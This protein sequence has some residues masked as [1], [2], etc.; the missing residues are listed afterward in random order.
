MRALQIEDF[1]IARRE[2][3]D[4]KRESNA[5][6]WMA[7]TLIM[8][9]AKG[10]NTRY[11]DFFNRKVAAEH[12]YVRCI[13][14]V[15][16][17]VSACVRACVPQRESVCVCVCVPRPLF[18]FSSRQPTRT[19]H[20]TTTPWQMKEESEKLKHGGNKSHETA[21]GAAR[22]NLLDDLLGLQEMVAE[23]VH[24]FGKVIEAEII[25]NIEGMVRACGRMC[26]MVTDLPLSR[27]WQTPTRLTDLSDCRT[28]I[29][30]DHLQITKFN[31]SIEEI[32]RE[33]EEFLEDFELAESSVQQA[34]AEYRD[35]VR[36]FV[37][38]F[39]MDCL[40]CHMPALTPPHQPPRNPTP[41]GHRPRRWRS[42]ARWRRTCGC[43]RCA[44]AWRWACCRRR[45]P[46]APS[47]WAASSRA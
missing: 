13:L 3:Y 18:L 10:E 44:T 28:L 46:S 9:R 8:K 23:K 6:Y 30:F 12:T 1:E 25:P 29:H 19:H 39:P 42:W 15:R 20:H 32:L 26:V 31:S 7:F 2:Y 21:F 24:A 22:K 41:A 40:A 38:F 14:E 47:P 35:Q 11:L 43:T 4:H 37:P 34:Y 45:G 33:G 16:E 17:C 27:P 5:M 36:P